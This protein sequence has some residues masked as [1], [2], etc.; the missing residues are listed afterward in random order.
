ML[1]RN[2]KSTLRGLM[3]LNQVVS[4]VRLL[5]CLNLF[6]QRRFLGYP[7]K[8]NE[9]YKLELLGLGNLRTVRA[10]ENVVNK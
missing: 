10:L 4:K 3:V 6:Q 7:T 2:A 5:T 9:Y 1:G 8:H